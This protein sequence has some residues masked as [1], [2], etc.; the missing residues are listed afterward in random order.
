M[1]TNPCLTRVSLGKILY[2]TD[3]SG[4]SE[5]ALPFVTSIARNYGATVNALHVLTP[6]PMTYTTPELGDAALAGDEEFAQ[7][8]MR[9]VDSQLVGVTHETSIEWSSSIWPIV[10]R[11]IEEEHID[12]IV[13]GTHGRTGAQKLLLGSVA[14]E[15]FRKSSVPVLTI[16]PAITGGAHANGQFRN[17]LFATDFQS[18]S[19]AAARYAISF[20]QENQARLTILHVL[21]GPRR[22]DGHPA[23]RSVAEVLHLLMETVQP[24]AELRCRPEAVIEYGDPAKQILHTAK[25]RGADLIVLGLHTSIPHLSSGSRNLRATAHK[26]VSHS[27]CPVLT[28]RNQGTSDVEDLGL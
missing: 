19:Q 3:F 7:A 15:I 18:E 20:A 25:Q 14:E 11:T 13:V 5:A 23:P 10:E 17:V 21:P 8:E 22:S 12:L 26:I 27:V 16:G 4:A 28:A 9:K 1:N 2:L 6:A 24:E